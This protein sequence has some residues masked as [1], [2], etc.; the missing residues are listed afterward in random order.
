MRSVKDAIAYGLQKA[1]YKDVR[2]HQRKVIEGYCS[3]KDVFLSAPTG[4]GKS[5]TFEV[6]PYVF[7]Y[8]EHGERLEV[9]SV[10]LVVVPLVAL[11]KDQ[12]TSLVARGIS[13]AS[14]G[15]DCTR[16]QVKEISEGKYSLVFGSPEAL[17]NSHRSIF[18]GKLRK[19]LKAVFVDESHCIA[20][21]GMGTKSEEAFRKDYSRPG[22]LR[23]LVH[24]DVPFITLTATAKE[25]V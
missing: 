15:A 19:N 11:M 3:G 4:S 18:H 1:Q 5:L 23:S 12:V 14:V 10:C 9:C 22:E 17:L 21:W 20:K 6:A 7:D 8:L 25:S 13:A 16:E 2:E 24:H